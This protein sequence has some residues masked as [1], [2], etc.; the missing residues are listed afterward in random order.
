LA[1]HNL[2]TYLGQ[3]VATRIAAKRSRVICGDDFRYTTFVGVGEWKGYWWEEKQRNKELRKEFGEVM[4]AGTDVVIPRMEMGGPSEKR[5]MGE[6][7]GV[8]RELGRITIFIG[9]TKDNGGRAGTGAGAV[10]GEGERR[11]TQASSGCRSI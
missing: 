3:R 2:S 8:A 10:F 5:V 9:I 4:N 7:K 11:K 1:G 6:L